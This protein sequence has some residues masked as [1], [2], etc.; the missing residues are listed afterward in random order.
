MTID[1]ALAI[2]AILSA[3]SEHSQKDPV[4]ASVPVV[5]GNASGI[6]HDDRSSS[7]SDIEE[8]PQTATKENGVA[9]TSPI[10]EEAAYDTEAE[11]ERLE[12]SPHK[13]R[14]QLNITLSVSKRRGVDGVEQEPITLAQS[15]I[16]EEIYI[17]VVSSSRLPDE[18]FDQTSDI[19][20]LGD[21]DEAGASR[22]HSPTNLA[23]K[24]R[25]RS[26]EDLAGNGDS[27]SSKPRKR[28]ATQIFTELIDN[29]GEVDEAA[30]AFNEGDTRNAA[31]SNEDA[32]TSG[33]ED[34]DAS[35]LLHPVV[36]SSRRERG[37][38]QAP[39]DLDV[40]GTL[41]RD[42]SPGANDDLAEVATVEGDVD[43]EISPDA[44]MDVVTR[45]EEEISKKKVALD[46]LSAIEKHF[47]TLRDKLF[48]ERLTQLNDEL[49]MLNQPNITHPDYLAMMEAIDRRRDEKI[50]NADTRLRFKLQAL[51]NKTVA[52]RAICHGQY[53][54][55][56]R[57]ITDKILQEA[58]KELYA[59]QRE[60][61]IR[62]EE[63]SSYFR[64]FQTRRSKQIVNQTAYNTEVSI[65]SGIA[66]YKGFPAAP[67]ITGAK[68]SDIDEDMRRMG[69]SK[70]TDYEIT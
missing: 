18:A 47:A 41:S 48:D 70:T 63:E 27:R 33:I 13:N 14:K 34:E 24:K 40:G 38:D 26:R 37:R 59:I 2:D 10:S 15:S 50:E 51:G 28:L 8:R 53:M 19:S 32:D 9:N 30:I 43:G 17:P 4:S 1:P 60:R 46:A 20:S 7:L 69:V 36:Y 62:E 55:E 29:D 35:N 11:T 67:E 65:L 12:D 16:V 58:N 49:E 3:A 45:N 22:R 61:K 66:Q 44:D 6:D 39:Q 25:K 23:G 5:V 57:E 64:H 56:V 68:A 54:Q 42:I 21:S 52:T 31:I